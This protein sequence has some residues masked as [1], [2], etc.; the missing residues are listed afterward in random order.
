[1]TTALPDWRSLPLADLEREFNPRVSVPDF[2]IYL[3]RAAS[4]SRKVRDELRVEPDIRY[5]S[6]PRQCVDIYPA[7][8][9]NAPA[10]VY[11]HGG[12]WRALSKEQFAG[13]SA[14]L[15][16]RGITTVVVG[17]DLCPSVTLDELV[18]EIAQALQW[19]MAN[20]SAY[21]MDPERLHLVGSSAGAHLVA[22]AMMKAVAEGSWSPQFCSA[23]LASGIYELQPVLSISVNSDIRLDESAV[24]RNSPARHAVR[25]PMPLFIAAGADESKS[26]IG[27]SV[28]FG[29][30][31]IAAGNQV[32]L[33]IVP[34]AH[35]FSLGIGAEGTV[36]NRALIDHVERH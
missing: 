36:L 11:V 23:W 34:G 32:E 18:E 20:A 9:R 7:A 30:A 27:Q 5:G 21:R 35:H 8:A 25:L 1:M 12:F 29:D 24:D 13:V 28:A 2:Q 33:M 3:D 4:A 17:Y 14:S 16:P 22:M 10:V 6:G 26:L 15:H 19:V 31:C